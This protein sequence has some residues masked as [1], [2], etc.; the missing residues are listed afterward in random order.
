M[1]HPFW[2]K[3]N[4]PPDSIDFQAL[5]RPGAFVG[6][7]ES[8]GSIVIGFGEEVLHLSEQG[9]VN[10]IADLSRGRHQSMLAMMILDLIGMNTRQ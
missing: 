2:M 10:L 3:T 8:C 5:L 4:I 6:R 9:A 1:H 7:C